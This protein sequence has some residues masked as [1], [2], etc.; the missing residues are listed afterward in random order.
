ML[1]S[2]LRLITRRSSAC[3]CGSIHSIRCRVTNFGMNFSVIL[4]GRLIYFHPSA[5]AWGRTA[6]IRWSCVM[7]V[8]DLPQPYSIAFSAHPVLHFV[9]GCNYCCSYP[10]NFLNPHS[11]LLCSS[12]AIFLQFCLSTFH[13]VV[14]FAQLSPWELRIVCSVL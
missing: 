10:R 6:A 4:S 11:L 7:T 5:T 3:G 2:C 8:S 9:P 14:I 12:L 13:S 1:A